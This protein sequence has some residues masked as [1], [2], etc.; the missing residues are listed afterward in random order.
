MHSNKRWTPVLISHLVLVEGSLKS[1]VDITCVVIDPNLCS[2]YCVYSA[3]GHVFNKL[4][5]LLLLIM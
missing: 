5:D 3:D 2:G 1:F 4:S